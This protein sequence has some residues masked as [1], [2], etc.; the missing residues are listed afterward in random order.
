MEEMNKFLYMIN[1]ELGVTGMEL[2]ELLDNYIIDGK[3]VEYRI[4]PRN[5]I[6]V[7]EKDIFWYDKKIINDTIANLSFYH[8]VFLPTVSAPLLIY[9]MKKNLVFFV[10]PRE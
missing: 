6:P 4:I 10:F 3:T 7:S 2:N 8:H 1:E 9:D 5:C